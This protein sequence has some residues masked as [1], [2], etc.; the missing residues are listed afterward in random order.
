MQHN[1]IVKILKG[2][3]HFLKQIFDSNYSLIDSAESIFDGVNEKNPYNFENIVIYNPDYSLKSGKSHFDSQLFRLDFNQDSLQAVFFK[4]LRNDRGSIDAVVLF[5]IT[6]GGR[7]VAIV[8]LEYDLNSVKSA[9]FPQAVPLLF[10]VLVLPFFIGLFLVVMIL[11]L[12]K[13]IN[14]KEKENAKITMLDPLTEFFNKDYFFKV[15]K[16]EIER[17]KQKQGSLSLTVCDLRNFF[18]IYEKYGFDFAELII[19]AIAK[20]IGDNYRNYDVKGRFGDDEFVILMVNSTAEE[21]KEF[22]D[23]CYRKIEESKFYY[24]GK[25]ITITAD[26]GIAILTADDINDQSDIDNCFRDLTFN[27]LKA[28]SSAKKDENECVVVY[29]TV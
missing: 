11:N 25:E 21:S 24:D 28:L 16:Q 14:S 10:I 20:I 8:Q 29:N 18:N 17:I 5:K 15:L 1:A 26:F 4:I 27:A 7:C 6:N 3:G 12:Y 22:A 23:N 13:R 9:Y 2:E 19:Q